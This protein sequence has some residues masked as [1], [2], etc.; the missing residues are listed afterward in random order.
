MA[1]SVGD[2]LPEVTLQGLNGETLALGALRGKRRLLFFL[3]LVVRLP[4]A[5][6]RVAAR[7]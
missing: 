3:G 7:V 2:R 5:T 4:R 1:V 6:A